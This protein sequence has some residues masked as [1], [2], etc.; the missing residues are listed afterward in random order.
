MTR[1][2]QAMA[3]GPHGGAERQFVRL[4]LALHRA[5][6]EQ[7]IL[8]RRDPERAAALA[9]GGLKPVELAFG[10]PLDLL[11]GPGSAARSPPSPRHCSPDEPGDAVLLPGGADGGASSMPPARRLLRPQIL[12]ALRSSDRQHPT[13]SITC[14][15][16]A[17]RRKH[18]LSAERRRRSGAAADRTVFATPADAKLALALGRLHANKGFDVLLH[19][20]AELPGLWLWIAG[21][22]P[23]D[24]ALK[25]L[26]E[27]L[28]VAERVRFLGWREDTAALLA[29]ADV[30]VVPSRRE[31]FGNAL[32][33]AWAQR[34]PVVAAASAGPAALVR[35]EENGLLVLVE[36]APALAAAIGRVIGDAALA[37]RRRPGRTGPDT[38]RSPSRAIAGSSIAR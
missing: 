36:D 7:R 29:A 15:A 17:G 5:G 30:L 11:S 22:G 33:E 28:G 4:T 34:V 8:I 26:A 37:E 9:A 16:P 31:P 3:G 23:L 13:S 32:V 1:V 6:I 38:R 20:L 19:A 27:R 14:G 24:G 12:S 21:D 18:A 25:R 2:L 10:G 35:P